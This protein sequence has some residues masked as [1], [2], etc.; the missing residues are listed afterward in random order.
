MARRSWSVW[1]SKIANRCGNRTIRDCYSI[2]RG[3]NFS[4]VRRHLLGHYCAAFA[5]SCTDVLSKFIEFTGGKCQ[6]GPVVPLHLAWRMDECAAVAGQFSVC[7]Q[8]LP[9]DFLSDIHASP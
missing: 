6:G 5:L 2:E 4:A 7:F 9:F 8:G 1:W 3:P